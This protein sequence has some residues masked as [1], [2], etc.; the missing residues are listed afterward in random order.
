MDPPIPKI[1]KGC[2]QLILSKGPPP[3]I[4]SHTVHVVPST[5]FE[6]NF[7]NVHGTMYM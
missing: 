2:F 6:L 3:T 7:I 4:A 5:Y 1:A